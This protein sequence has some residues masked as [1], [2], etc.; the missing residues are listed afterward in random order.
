MQAVR[1]RHSN[2]HPEVS[3]LFDIVNF[4]LLGT[5]SFAGLRRDL[6]SG[7]SAADRRPIKK[8]LFSGS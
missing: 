6:L 1:D 7:R 2:L 4:I 8:P 3:A 5:S